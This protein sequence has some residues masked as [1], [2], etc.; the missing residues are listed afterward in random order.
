[1]VKIVCFEGVHGC[2]KGTLIDA[3]QRELA[4]H[5]SGKHAVIR[6]SEYP[7]FEQVKKAIRIGGLSGKREIIETVARTRAQIYIDHINQQL[8]ALDLAILDRSYYTSAVCQSESYEEMYEI[9]RENEGR[10]IPR[11]DLTFILH[12][13][14]DVIVH[15]LGKR[16]RPDLGEHDAARTAQEQR[17]YL[18]LAQNCRECVALDTRDDPAELARDVYSVISANKAR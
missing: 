17:K 7:E 11:A 5:S 1:M 2:G 8:Q 3:L 12:A 18:H 16:R 6:D 14:I 4:N 9:I 13:P 10:G 15:R